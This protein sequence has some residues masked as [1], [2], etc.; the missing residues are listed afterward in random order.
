[1][2]AIVKSRFLALLEM[3]KQRF[4]TLFEAISLKRLQIHNNSL[5]LSVGENTLL[6]RH[7]RRKPLNPV[8]LRLKDRLLD[9]SFINDDLLFFPI[10]DHGLL[11]SKDTLE[12]RADLRGPICR[13]ACKAAFSIQQ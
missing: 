4:G 6:R 13:M 11:L 8:D 12:G 10:S 9:E 5:D 1:M 2:K 3:S 7:D